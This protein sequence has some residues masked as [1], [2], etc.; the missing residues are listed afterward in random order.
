[1]HINSFLSSYTKLKAKSIKDLNIKGDILK[2]IPEKV[3]KS[4]KHKGK[5]ENFS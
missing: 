1:M 3:E 2:L 4:L 5:G